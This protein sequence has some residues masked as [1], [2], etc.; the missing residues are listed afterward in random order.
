MKT[1]RRQLHFNFIADPLQAKIKIESLN[2]TNPCM[3]QININHRAVA[4]SGRAAA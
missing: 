1:G 2:T 3:H 4:Q